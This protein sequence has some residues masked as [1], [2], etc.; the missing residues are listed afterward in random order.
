VHARQYSY[1]VIRPLSGGDDVTGRQ[2]NC[3]R[4]FASV[5]H[6]SRG[7]K[8]GGEWAWQLLTMI[9]FFHLTLPVLLY[10][11]SKHGHT[12]IASFHSNAVLLLQLRQFNSSLLASVCLSVCLSQVRVLVKRLNVGS[13]KQRHTIAQVPILLVSSFS[14]AEDLAKLKRGHP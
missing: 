13:R 12:K 9:Y 4:D 14:N 5:E 7:L 10:Y 8:R 3:G 2:P 6:G 1:R 11:M